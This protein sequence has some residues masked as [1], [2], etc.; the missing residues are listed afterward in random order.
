[1]KPVNRDGSDASADVP[2]D[3]LIISLRSYVTRNTK[4]KAA[5]GAG[6]NGGASWRGKRISPQEWVLVFDCETRTTPDQQLRFG[7]YQLRHRGRLIQRGA[8][9]DP[10]LGKADLDVLTR[11]VANE[12][13]GDDGERIF[14][15]TRLEFIERVLFNSAYNVGAQIVGFNLPFDLSRLAI[16][17]TPARRSMKGGFSLILHESKEYPRVVVKHLSQRSSIIQFA[18]VKSGKGKGGSSDDDE[19]LDTEKRDP[20]RGYFVDVKTFAAALL[21]ASHSLE[22]LS[23]TLKVATPKQPSD[24]H[25]EALKP[26]YV[27]YAFNDTQTTWECFEALSKQFASLGLP[28]TGA[29]DLYSEASLGK[30]YLD[31]M[32]VKPWMIV[33]PEFPPLIIGNILS[34]YYGG[35]SEV[36][37]R[38]QITEVLHFDFLSMYPTVCTLMGLW[39]YVRAE[40]ITYADDTSAVRKFVA[41]CTPEDLKAQAHW[42]NLNALVQVLPNKDLF[43]VRAAYGDSETATIGLNYLTAGEPM[44]FTLADVLV[45]KM[46]TGKAPQIVKAFRFKPKESQKGLRP[47]VVAGRQVDPIKDDFYKTLI[48][49]RRTVKA[50]ADI[51]KGSEKERLNAEQQGIKILANATSYGIFVELN[52]QDLSK[53]E[54]MISHGPY[55]TA[56]KCSTDDYEKPGRYFHPLLATLITGAAR[57]MLSLAE[58]QVINQGLDWVFCD[59]DSLAIAKQ[60]RYSGKEFKQR[61]LKVRDWFSDLN[62]YEQKGPILQLEKVNFPTGIEG[63]LDYLTPPQC[64]AISAKRYALFNRDADGNPVIRKASGHGLGHLF[65]PYD[66]PM[67]E[68]RERIRRIGVPSWEEDFWREIIRAA[69]SK[70]PDQVPLDSR[71]NISAASQYAATKP[72]MLR[73]FEIYN[74]DKS[75]ADQV[76]PF[77]FLLSLYAKS[78]IQMALDDSAALAGPQWHRREPKPAAPYYTD[79]SKAARHAFDRERPDQVV[80]FEWLKSLGRNLARYHLHREEKF[81]GGDYDQRG[82]LERRHVYALAFQPIGKEADDIDER[83][84]LGEDE[85]PIERPFAVHAQMQV[86]KFVD[87]TKRECGISERDLIERA[88]V[89]HHT[90]GAA[91]KG[92]L[93]DAATLRKIAAA[94]VYL[95]QRYLNAKSETEEL[96]DWAREAMIDIGGRNAFARLIDTDPSYL[97]RVLADQKTAS[98]G[99]L[100]KFKEPKRKA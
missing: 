75:Y 62:P 77:N 26:E 73:W 57:L 18:G 27:C 64:L 13:P 29:Y 67:E 58:R 33:Q 63:D 65:A 42:Q 44:W 99:L 11:E 17:H 36:H 6:G 70:E 85:D 80:P 97:G 95:R 23:K 43:P 41:G 3:Q 79:I 88:K 96:L 40:G 56:W 83:E 12:R 45:S 20:D 51:A 30:V 93:Q 69:D 91:R 71:F 50:R 48:D 1:M 39:D 28:D 100:Q 46:L 54:D 25:G 8:F 4:P 55:S 87:D 5:S 52:V 34:A 68:R 7:T 47:V 72:D 81:W 84:A 53:P 66:E 82:V 37:I 24:E 61:A 35:R 2:V 19:P 15:L 92:M 94:A 78:R 60:P 90:L 76:K 9:Y 32:G 74:K 14:L 98:D 22:S 49:H 38:R 59:T 21:S 89:S 16:G 10:A 31:A 86:M